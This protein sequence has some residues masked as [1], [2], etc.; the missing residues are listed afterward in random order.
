[1]KFVILIMLFILN[2]K[3][4]FKSLVIDLNKIARQVKALHET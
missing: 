1:M 3:N 4:W 2:F